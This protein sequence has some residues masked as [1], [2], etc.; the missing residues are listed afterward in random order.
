MAA[1]RLL[2][3]TTAS[4]QPSGQ[5]ILRGRRSGQSTIEFALLYATV[6]VPMTFGILFVSEMCW[7]WHSMVEFT[8]DGARYAATHCW[9]SDASNVVSYMQA[10]I[11]R[12]VD[13]NQF[14]AGGTAQ[15]VVSYFQRDPTS[16]QLTAFSCGGGDCSINCV[17]DAVTVSLTNYQFQAF[18][19]SYLHLPPVTMPSFLTSVPV[20]SGGCD[21][22]QNVCN[23]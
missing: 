16:G 5:Q 3:T 2:I 7:V 4:A 18:I 15:I 22:E 20:E 1:L 8:R 12:T 9:E 14:Q 10:N 23:P 19:V 17:P 6:L 21:P 13:Q 11:P